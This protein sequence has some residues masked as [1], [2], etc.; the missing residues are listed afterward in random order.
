MSKKTS[1]A[2]ASFWI[3]GFVV[4]LTITTLMLAHMWQRSEPPAPSPS[5]SAVVVVAPS[6]SGL[7]DASGNHLH[8]RKLVASDELKELKVSRGPYDVELFQR[9]ALDGDGRPRA[10]GWRW[11]PYP[12]AIRVWVHG[13]SSIRCGFFP[14]LYGLGW[15]VAYCPD[16]EDD[17]KRVP[18]KLW[19]CDLDAASLDV[20]IEGLVDTRDLKVH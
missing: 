18:R 5:S 16:P 8:G 20:E 19:I 10:S 9:D 4:A 11:D 3:I 15:R 2:I 14:R 13:D 17:D 7:V 6:A 1:V 12:W